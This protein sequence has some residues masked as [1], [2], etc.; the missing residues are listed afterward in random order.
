[1]SKIQAAGL[2]DRQLVDNFNCS[3]FYHLFCEPPN[4]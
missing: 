3:C 4:E 1:M 2:L